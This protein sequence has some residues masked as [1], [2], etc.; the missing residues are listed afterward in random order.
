MNTNTIVF[1]PHFTLLYTVNDI[2][3]IFNPQWI[4]LHLVD[5]MISISQDNVIDCAD[6]NRQSH[7]NAFKI[8]L[9]L[10]IRQLRF[11]LHNL[12]LLQQIRVC[13]DTEIQQYI[14][15]SRTLSVSNACLDRILRRLL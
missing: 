2:N 6:T 5:A 4:A 13:N 10:E 11:L 15:L 14:T 8:A 12:Y 9:M 7:A 3:T 1:A